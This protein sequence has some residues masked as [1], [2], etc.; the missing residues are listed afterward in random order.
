MYVAIGSVTGVVLQSLPQPGQHVV[1]LDS[2][3]CDTVSLSCITKPVQPA[4]KA[5]CFV[6]ASYKPF[7]AKFL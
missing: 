2:L 1:L 4:G 7:T 6:S 5:R 3:A